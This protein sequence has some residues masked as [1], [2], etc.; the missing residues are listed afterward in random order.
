LTKL[1]DDLEQYANDAYS[2][3]DIVAGL[4]LLAE[5]IGVGSV[6]AVAMALTTVTIPFLGPGPSRY[7]TRGL[8]QV[9][10]NEY[11]ELT[12]EDRKLVRAAMS[13]VP[14]P[15]DALSRFTD[16]LEELKFFFSDVLESANLLGDKI[17]EL[18]SFVKRARERFRKDD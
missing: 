11:Q 2:R 4:K 15:I 3:K 18:G 6:A 17:E 13:I 16:R 14:N 10:V 9:L 1:G 12:T 5:L 8:A 7:V